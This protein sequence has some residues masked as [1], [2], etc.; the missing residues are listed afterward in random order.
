MSRSN[1]DRLLASINSCASHLIS[2]SHQFPPPTSPS[3]SLLGGPNLVKGPGC[4]QTLPCFSDHRASFLLSSP[5][6]QAITGICFF[7]SLP[8]SPSSPSRGIRRVGR[9]EVG[10]GRG[11]LALCGERLGGEEPTRGRP[12]RCRRQQRQHDAIASPFPPPQPLPWAGRHQDLRCF[13][14]H[15]HVGQCASLAPLLDPPHFPQ[16]G[17]EG[18][19]G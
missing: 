10:Y 19:E 5:H 1:Q 4:A 12:S 17:M 6:Y 13:L 2:Q 11:R 14:L 8:F 16:E 9:C 7:L 3:M 18:R 15:C